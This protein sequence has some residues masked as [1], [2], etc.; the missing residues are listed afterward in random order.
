MKYLC[1]H[2]CTLMPDSYGQSDNLNIQH[3]PVHKH[4]VLTSPALVAQ[5]PIQKLEKSVAIQLE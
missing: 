3:F 5:R 2:L 1:R 4:E